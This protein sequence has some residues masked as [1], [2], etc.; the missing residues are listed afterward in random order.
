MRKYKPSISKPKEDFFSAGRR[1]GADPN[2]THQEPS[3]EG[4]NTG[5]KVKSICPIRCKGETE[6]SKVSKGSNSYLTFK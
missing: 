2:C 4:R 6:V 1:R 3:R 5:S